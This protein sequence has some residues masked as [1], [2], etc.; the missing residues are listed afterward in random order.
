MNVKRPPL[1]ALPEVLYLWWLGRADAPRLVGTLRWVRRAMQQHAGVSLRYAPAWLAQGFAL[2]EDLPLRDVEYLPQAPDAAVG[3]VD[4]ARPDRWGERIIRFLIQP[5]RLSTLDYLY[6]AGDGRLGGLGVSTSATDYQPYR[7][8]VLPQLADV[9][10]VHDLIRQVEAQLPLDA[11][12]LRLV[13]PGATLGGTKPKALLQMEG[14]EWVL[15]FPEAGDL[16][17]L[18]LVEHASLTLAQ[19]CGIE[20]SQTRLVPYVQNG[21]TRHALAVRRFDREGGAHRRHAQS[22]HVAL[23]AAGMDYGYPEMALLLRRLGDARY[24]P[25]VGDQLFRRM[26][27]NICIDNT[28]DH[29][30]NHVF[31][32]TGQALTLAPAFDVLPTLLSLGVQS[33]RVGRAGADA[34]LE[35]ALS[36][37][38]AFGL[39][40]AQAMQSVKDVVRVVNGWQAHFMQAGVCPQDMAIL[41]QHIDRPFLIAQRESIE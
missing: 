12:K 17:D 22:A 23:R 13:S 41:R 9:Q 10:E 39:T 37:H 33:M 20:V 27:F 29:E 21:Q 16:V 1:P 4:D 38:K 32:G 30:K 18:G 34:T 5:L 24:W 36:D 35:N 11:A 31:L 26:V 14:A 40:A 7:H 3:A 8:G 6:Y 28:D 25:Q 15:K 2:S 19:T